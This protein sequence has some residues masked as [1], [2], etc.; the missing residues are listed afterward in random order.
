MPK[1]KEPTQSQ[2]GNGLRDYSHLPRAKDFPKPKKLTPLQK[3]LK[4]ATHEAL[5]ALEEEEKKYGIS[6]A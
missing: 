1:P 6:L 2:N 4:K 3:E 5:K